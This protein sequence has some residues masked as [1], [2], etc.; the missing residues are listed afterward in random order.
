M[1]KPHWTLALWLRIQEPRVVTLAQTVIYLLCALGGII[2]IIAPPMSI[3]VKYGPYVTFA[4]GSFALIGGVLGTWAAPAGKWLIEKPAIIACTTALTLYAGFI[5]S[6]QLTVPG[7]RWVQLCF[8]LMVIAH[9]IGRYARI[10][11][12]SYEPGK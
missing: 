9:F 5:L 7:N 3:E 1:N 4:W 6:L 11:P 10:R 2:A 8:V 12:Y